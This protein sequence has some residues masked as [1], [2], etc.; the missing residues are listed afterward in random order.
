MKEV[1]KYISTFPEDVQAV[2]SKIRA[3]IKAAAP[4]AE[5]TISY[6][7]PAFR[8][9]KILVYYAAFKHHI[10]LFPP[11]P[12][13]LRDEAT[14]Y[15]GP[16]YNLRFPLD[17]PMPYSLITKIVKERVRIIKKEK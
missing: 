7:M 5:E 16:K 2:L 10:G 14:K 1:D 3:T 12:E 8:Q 13:V 9:N 6:Q 11:V 17:E 15:A 4:E